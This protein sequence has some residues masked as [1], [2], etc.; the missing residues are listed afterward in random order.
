MHEPPPTVSPAEGP[1]GAHRQGQGGALGDALPPTR[2]EVLVFGENPIENMAELNLLP[3]YRFTHPFIC[4]RRLLL[5]NLGGD[6]DT[7]GDGSWLYPLD[8]P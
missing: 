8:F 6:V 4:R 5:V 2:G 7:P 3:T 1:R